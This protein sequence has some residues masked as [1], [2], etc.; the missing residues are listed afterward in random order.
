MSRPC[1]YCHEESCCF[2][3]ATDTLSKQRILHD[4]ML[5]VVINAKKNVSRA[6]HGV[7]SRGADADH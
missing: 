3:R 1:V 7:I 5:F 2:E 4:E 6:E